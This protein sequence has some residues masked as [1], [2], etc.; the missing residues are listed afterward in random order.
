MTIVVS[1]D[2]LDDGVLFKLVESVFDFFYYI[3]HVEH[4][5]ECLVDGVKPVDINSYFNEFL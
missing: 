5:H 1:L 4:V 2:E 3:F